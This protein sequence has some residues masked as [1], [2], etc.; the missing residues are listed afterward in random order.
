MRLE[1]F[2]ETPPCSNGFRAV[3]SGTPAGIAANSQFLDL[4][5]DVAGTE[6][7]LSTNQIGAG[8]LRP[9]EMRTGTNNNQLFLATDG[10]V[11][12]G[13]G[14]PTSKLDVSGSIEQSGNEILGQSLLINGSFEDGSP[15]PF[16]STV[17]TLT[18]ETTNV[19]YGSSALD[20]TSGTTVDVEACVTNTQW[21]GRQAEVGCYVKSTLNDIS[22]CFNDGTILRWFRRLEVRVSKGHT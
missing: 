18:T 11:G 12:V 17:G 21:E 22:L 6:Y 19:L 2:C 13:T 7:L 20:I 1:L 8:V 4:R 16:T 3:G 5:Y 15:G 10:A 9:L 14:S